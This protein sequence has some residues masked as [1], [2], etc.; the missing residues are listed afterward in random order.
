M[1]SET[2]T[3]GTVTVTKPHRVVLVLTI[4]GYVLADLILLSV[5]GWLWGWWS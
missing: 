3:V 4:I 2:V 1:V 5:F